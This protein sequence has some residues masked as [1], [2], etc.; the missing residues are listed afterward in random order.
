MKPPYEITS[1]GATLKNTG[2]GVNDHEL[3]ANFHAE[4]IKETVIL[5]G[6]TERVIFTIKGG[7]GKRKFKQIDVP[8]EKFQSLS[9]ITQHWGAAAVVFPGNSSSAELRT[10]I[11]MLSENI[12]YE[13]VY[14]HTGWT[15]IDD[16]HFYLHTQGGISRK[17]N[18]ESIRVELPADLSRYALPTVDF[19]SHETHKAAWH[20]S[21]RLLMLAEPSK[22]AP[23]LC[24]VWR[25]PIM[26]SDFAVHCTGRSGSF[27]S[28]VTSLM[29]SHFGVEM[30][31]RN[32]PGSWTST[33]NALE[34]LAY[35]IKDAIFVIDDF[36][37]V[38]TS[39]QQKQ[40]QGNADRIMRGQGN[41]QGRARLTDISSLQQ[42]MYPRGLIISSGEDTPEGQS[43]R[44]RMMIV[45]LSKGDVNADRLTKAQADRQLLPHAMANYIQWLAAS[46]ESI[47]Q[48]QKLRRMEIR[49]ANRNVGHARTPQMIGDLLAAAETFVEHGLEME[50]CSQEDAETLLQQ[51]EAGLKE[52]GIDQTRFIV[53]SD[54]AETF[55]KVFQSA[56][57]AMRVHLAS[58]EGGQPDEPRMMG[59]QEHQS[60][61]VYSYTPK[62]VKIGWA[63]EEKDTI[64]LDHAVAYDELKKQS[65]GQ[66]A[67]TATTLWKRLKEAG[68]LAATDE[69]RK[70][71]TMRMVCE[72]SQKQVVAVRLS[73]IIEMEEPSDHIPY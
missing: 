5:D 3:L 53:E 12:E 68:L 34:A 37:P 71:N 7:N 56:L 43:L 20:A 41:Q 50:F 26:P 46:R 60:G 28:E 4:I 31:A 8:A 25:A 69:T 11:Q 15:V 73:A 47:K 61:T 35:R 18:D 44:G 66:I 22:M 33:A 32:L 10:A 1:T 36:I 19:E 14:Q 27:K 65:G 24:A 40:Y 9:W 38:G 39:W 67:V 13:T 2:Q 6:Q 30:D 52:T 48:N 54:V 42:T 51:I 64:Y 59:W 45:E 29:Q 17:G 16:E 49:D 23:L 55:V 72:K 63:D 62:G 21:R 70:R 58:I 57:M